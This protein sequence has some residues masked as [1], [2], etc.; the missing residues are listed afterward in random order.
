[1]RRVVNSFIRRPSDGAYNVPL[2]TDIS[3]GG[4]PVFV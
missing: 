4:P 3:T 2:A 1:M